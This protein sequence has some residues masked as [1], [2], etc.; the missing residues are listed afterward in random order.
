MME[1]I[2][3]ID[4]KNT[5]NSI[6]QKVM[7]RNLKFKCPVIAT[8]ISNCCMCPARLFIIGGGE[9]LFKVGTTKGDPTSMG[10][11]ILGISPLLQ[12][13]IDFISVNKL[14]AKEVGFCR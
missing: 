7:L 8:Y 6:N 14:N 4:A 3:L 2:L 10:A 5:F 9:L 12:F 11:Y 1:G 13:F